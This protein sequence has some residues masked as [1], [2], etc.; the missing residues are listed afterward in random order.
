MPIEIIGEVGTPGA[1]PV[2]IS[3]QA[4]LAIRHIVKICGPLRQRWSWKS[5]GRSMN[6]VAIPRSFSSGKTP[7]GNTVELSR[8][9]SGGADCLREWR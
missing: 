1:N 3:A 9:M 6:S 2:W 7:C 5:S 8:K 4:T